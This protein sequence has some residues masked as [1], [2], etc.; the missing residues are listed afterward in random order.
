MDTLSIISYGGIATL[1]GLLVVFEI[2]DYK[3]SNYSNNN[4]YV[5]YTYNNV[6]VRIRHLFSSQYRIYVYNNCPIQTKKDRYGTY[7]SLKGRSASDIEYQIDELY[8]RN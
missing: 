2:K 8:Q 1:I 3:S 4:G 5:Y 7:F 6:A